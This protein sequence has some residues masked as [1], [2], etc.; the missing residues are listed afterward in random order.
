MTNDNPRTPIV[1]T[2]QADAVVMSGLSTRAI[3]ARL[4]VS[5]KAVTNRRNALMRKQ[6]LNRVRATPGPNEPGSAEWKRRD[7]KFVRALQAEALRLH[8][9]GKLRLEA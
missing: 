2:P 4:G 7:A 6:N 5:R 1:W 9:L 3:S 8:K